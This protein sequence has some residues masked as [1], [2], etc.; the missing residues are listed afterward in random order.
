LNLERAIRIAVE[1]H[2]GQTDK[3]GRP[4]ILH[5]L[6]VMMSLE[7]DDERIVG[8]LHDVVEDCPD[9]SVERLQSEGF[10][11]SIIEAIKAVT[12]RSGGETYEEF[13]DRAARDTIGRRVKRADLL[14]NLDASRMASVTQR[15]AERLDRYVR[16]L[17]RLDGRALEASASEAS[18]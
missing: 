7:T 15:D 4:Y 5:P 6:R 9:W 11:Q 8:V 14:D 12:K 2:A 18:A 3:A 10:D 16:A 1:A 13:V 17:A